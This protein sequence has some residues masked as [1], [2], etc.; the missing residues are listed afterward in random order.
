MATWTG[1]SLRPSRWAAFQR[2]WPKGFDPTAPKSPE[3]VANEI[4]KD[5]KA[6]PGNGAF[7]IFKESVE[8]WFKLNEE[9]KAHGNDAMLGH[10][11]LYALSKDLKCNIPDAIANQ[12]AVL[13]HHWNQHLLPALS[14]T[15]MSNRLAK[16]DTM[17]NII[18]GIQVQTLSIRDER[19]EARKDN[20]HSPILRLVKIDAE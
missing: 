14:E 9:L 8:A 5:G 18:G 4:W 3:V 12:S 10:S 20:L 11:Y 1:T 2:V 16:A 15:L 6:D 13:E 7:N 17:D 19:P